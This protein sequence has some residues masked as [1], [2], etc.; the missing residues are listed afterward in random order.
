MDI[1]GDK[2]AIALL[3]NSWHNYNDDDAKMQT[4]LA[5]IAKIGGERGREFDIKEFQG[6]VI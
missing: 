5:A 3:A 1:C 4:S 2:V 6:V